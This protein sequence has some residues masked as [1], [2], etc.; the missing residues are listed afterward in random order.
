MKALIVLFLLG[1]LLAASNAQFESC[2]DTH[3]WLMLGCYVQPSESCYE[4][5]TSN[6]VV[7]LAN[8]VFNLKCNHSDGQVIINANIDIFADPGCAVPLESI[9]WR[10]VPVIYEG[11]VANSTFLDSLTMARVG[12]GLNI[13]GESNLTL[14]Q[15]TLVTQLNSIPCWSGSWVLNQPKTI[16]GVGCPGGDSCIE[17]DLL[18]VHSLI[19]IHPFHSLQLQ[20]KLNRTGIFS[21]VSNRDPPCD[22]TQRSDVPAGFWLRKIP[23]WSC[24]V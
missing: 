17:H 16:G 9:T 12:W 6:G 21:T 3:L 20:L 24:P 2:L 10:G 19:L 1:F 7:W 22:P 8:Q 5:V 23:E 15:P 18:A 11:E 13:A 4:L 14:R